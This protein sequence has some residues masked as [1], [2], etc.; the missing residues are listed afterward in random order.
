MDVGEGKGPGDSQ[1]YV[2]GAVG[3]GACSFIALYDCN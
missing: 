1:D 3:R 2:N